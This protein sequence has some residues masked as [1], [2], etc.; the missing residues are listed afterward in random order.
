VAINLFM[1]GTAYF[2]QHVVSGALGTIFGTMFAFYVVKVLFSSL[3]VWIVETSDDKRDEKNYVLLLLVI[4]GLAPGVR[5]AL[6]LLA[7]V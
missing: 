3:A 1:G 4:F 2:E 5:D 7:G 6:R